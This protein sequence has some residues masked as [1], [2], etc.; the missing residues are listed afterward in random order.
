MSDTLAAALI[1][2]G[3]SLPESQI[4]T[5]ERYCA[6]LWDHNSRVNLTRHLDYT[7]FAARD[8]L[9]TAELAALLDAGEHVL[10][11]GSGGGVP[12]I[13]LAI[14]RPD[15]R[16]SLCE[17]IGKKARILESMVRE[18][19]LQVP[20]HA[21]RAENVVAAGNFT[22]LTARAVGPLPKM[23]PWFNRRWG[24]FGRMLLIK[25]PRWVEE[26]QSA[27]EAGLLDDLALD[28]VRSYPMPGRENQSVILQIRARSD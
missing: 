14:L 10:D 2:A 6:L 15:V 27:K 16:V 11:F 22:T 5:L 20:V 1:D 13:V 8:A 21:D 28:Q 26:N 18:L 23:L 25:G 3:L 9:D 7:T 12:G 19:E 24:E 17:C 4:E